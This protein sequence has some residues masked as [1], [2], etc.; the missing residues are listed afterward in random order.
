MS[1]LDSLDKIPDRI[2]PGLEKR[3]YLALAEP[4]VLYVLWRELC[5]CVISVLIVLSS[6][7]LAK[8]LDFNFPLV[9]GIALVIWMTYQEFYLH[10]RKYGQKLW[11]G[12]LDWSS[13]TAPFI[14]Y[15]LLK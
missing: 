1:I 4:P 10:P 8:Y 9:V 15:F 11:N 12:I 14:V 5:H 7:L 13:W 6:H 2:I 3:N